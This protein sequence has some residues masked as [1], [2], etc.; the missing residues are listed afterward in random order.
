[1]AI[2]ISPLITRRIS[3]LR[4]NWDPVVI[5]R[6]WL[7]LDASHMMSVRVILL[8]R[9][10]RLMIGCAMAT[11]GRR[12]VLSTCDPFT[13]MAGPS[14]TPMALNGWTRR[15]CWLCHTTHLYRATET[16]L[17]TPWGCGLQRR[18]ATSTLKTVCV[19]QRS[20]VL[21]QLTQSDGV[22]VISVSFQSTL[23]ATFR[24][25]WT[26]TWLRTSP[27]CSTPTIT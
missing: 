6:V 26:E 17:L 16:I 15:L 25:F 9:L 24:L 27:V 4:H 22:C 2:L 21:K 20:R 13:S 5:F 3:F 1:M 14:I 23:A 7:S 19:W 10:R 8:S 18:P 12:P 11:P